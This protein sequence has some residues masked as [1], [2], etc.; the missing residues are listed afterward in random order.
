LYLAAGGLLALGIFAA[1]LDWNPVIAEVRWHS[2]VERVESHA[3]VLRRAALESGQDPYLLAGLVYVESGGDPRAVSSV[4]ALGLFQLRLPTAVERAE[5]LGLSAPDRAELLA[6]PELNARLGAAYLTWL[7]DYCEGDLERALVCYNAGLGKV[8]GWIEEAGWEAWRA[9]R[10]AAGNS[11]VLR[12]A[13]DVVRFAERFRSRGRIVP[14]AVS[15]P[16]PAAGQAAPAP[17]R[18]P[19]PTDGFAR[20]PGFAA[21]P[22]PAPGPDPSPSAGTPAGPPPSSAAERQP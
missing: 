19:P 9:E 16:A 14:S 1:G 8:Q 7:V 13:S 21:P 5:V 4:D 20:P 17:L 10:L 15:D 6:D 18:A 3:E 22:A 2:R 12:Y 11:K